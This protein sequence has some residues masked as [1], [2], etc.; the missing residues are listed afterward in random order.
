MRTRLTSDPANEASPIWSP[1]GRQISF[2]SDRKD[3]TG[4]YQKASSGAGVE[5][6]LLRS[7]SGNARAF[8]WSVDGSYLLYQTAGA[9]VSGR[10]CCDLQILPLSGDKKPRAFL[11]NP[12]IKL[13]AKFSPDGRWVAYESNESGTR[14]EIYVVPFPKPDSK[15]LVSTAGGAWP[16][17]RRDGK[18]IFYL[19]PNRRLMVA[20][21]DGRGPSFKVGAVRPLFAIDAPLVARSAYDVSPDGQRFLVNVLREQSAAPAPLTVVSNWTAT[22]K[23]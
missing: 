10:A 4:L 6:L 16:R 22:L 7:D 12:F 9:R 5:E 14:N 18:E 13:R 1:D 17:W 15:F 11:E 23:K 2:D 3:G 8:S 20:D 21:V 19:D